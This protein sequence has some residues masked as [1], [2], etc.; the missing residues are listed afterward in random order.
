MPVVPSSEHRRDQR[1]RNQPRR[2]LRVRLVSQPVSVPG[3]RRFVRDGLQEWGRHELLDDAALCMTELAANAA[4][5]SGSR[6]MDVHL[7]DLGGPVELAVLDDGAQ[8]RLESVV[9]R[10]SPAMR[11]E[12]AVLVAEPT[13]GRG[14]AI[15]S[16]L[17]HDWGV[18]DVDGR[19]RVW[20]VLSPDDEVG[21][22]RPPRWDEP[23]ASDAADDVLPDGWKLIVVPQ[24]PVALSIRIDSNIDEVIRE[25]QLIDSSPRSPSA[26]LARLIQE[27]ISVPFARHTAR[28]QVLDAYDRGLDRIDV[29]LP[30][31]REAVGGIRGLLVAMRGA[32]DLCREHQLLA[33][34]ATEEMDLLREWYTHN[35]VT[36]LEDDAEPVLYDDWLAAR[37]G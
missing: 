27:L 18:A 16:M 17:A 25:L 5:H 35:M 32:D 23:I 33:V 12:T 29:R 34:P 4:L 37:A 30:T 31:P 20:A 9:P 14:L 2:D 36:Q 19:R 28:A 1:R 3:A 10:T 7:H 22:V 26:A 24:A 13:T 21:P 8:A 15:V 11:A 6:Y